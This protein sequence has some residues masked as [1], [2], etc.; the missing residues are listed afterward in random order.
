MYIKKF[1]EKTY[2][3]TWEKKI[4]TF[5]HRKLK[6]KIKICSEANDEA[7]TKN[8]AKIFSICFA[9]NQRQKKEWKREAHFSTRIVGF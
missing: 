7:S 9:F 8:T 3:R 6:K 2:M 4:H 5:T 1:Y